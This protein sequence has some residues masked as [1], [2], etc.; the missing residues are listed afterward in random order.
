MVD[1][2]AGLTDPPVVV[3]VLIALTLLFKGGSSVARAPDYG[4]PP[5]TR[6]PVAGTPTL[7]AD[8]RKCE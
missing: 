2:V 1:K 8:K 6:G 5:T 4:V 3:W 7:R